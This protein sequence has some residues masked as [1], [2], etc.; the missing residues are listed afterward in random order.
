MKYTHLAE[1]QKLGNFCKNI[2]KNDMVRFL[3]KLRMDVMIED[4]LRYSTPY[5]WFASFASVFEL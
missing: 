4:I 5:E 1:T 3:D 2:S